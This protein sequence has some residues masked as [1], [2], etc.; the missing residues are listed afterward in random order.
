MNNIVVLGN[1]VLVEMYSY[2]HKSENKLVD[3]NNNLLSEKYGKEV[4]NVAKVLNVGTEYSGSI[5]EGDI[6]SLVDELL[7]PIADGSKGFTNEGEPKA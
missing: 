7:E 5:K 2:D 3:L 1:T 6:V 4:F